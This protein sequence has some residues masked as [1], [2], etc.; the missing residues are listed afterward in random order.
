MAARCPAVATLDLETNKVVKILHAHM[1][2][3]NILHENAREEKQKIVE[4]AAI[5]ERVSTVEILSNLK[6]NLKR[7]SKP[8]TT[9]SNRRKSRTLAKAISR[10]KFNFP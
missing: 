8:E 4:A 7:S 2:T 5:V 10:E 1:H 3:S 9:F 6:S